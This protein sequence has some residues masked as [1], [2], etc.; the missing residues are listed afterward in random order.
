MDW[1]RSAV[2]NFNKTT[3]V[4]VGRRALCLIEVGLLP[5][6][7]V[8]LRHVLHRQECVCEGALWVNI[9][10][11]CD[12]FGQEGENTSHIFSFPE[13]TVLISCPKNIEFSR[14]FFLAEVTSIPLPHM[15]PNP[16]KHMQARAH[17]FAHKQ[18]HKQADPLT[19]CWGRSE[20]KHNFLLFCL[21]SYTL[22]VHS[23][24]FE[25]SFQI[26]NR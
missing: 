13:F 25:N 15:N 6:D 7:R 2:V 11:H 22:G 26:R 5:P 23:K 12:S 9:Y 8:Q 10:L 16:Q 18:T 17:I 14:I 1:S 21:F 3:E 20:S 4:V 19:M 24:I